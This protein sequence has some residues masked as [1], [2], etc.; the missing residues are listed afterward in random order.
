MGRGVKTL[1]GLKLNGSAGLQGRG[2]VTS[3]RQPSPARE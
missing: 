1:F 2:R 3:I